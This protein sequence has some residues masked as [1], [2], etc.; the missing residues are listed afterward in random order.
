VGI[1]EVRK[2]F[3]VMHLTSKNHCHCWTDGLS[4]GLARWEVSGCIH[5]SRPCGMAMPLTLLLF[6]Y[7]DEHE[8][9]GDSMFSLAS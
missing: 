4:T 6:R 8:L 9:G 7:I 2:A 3:L 1:F 5:H